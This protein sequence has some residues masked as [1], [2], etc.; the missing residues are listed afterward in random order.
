MFANDDAA[1]SILLL[2]LIGNKHNVSISQN[3]WDAWDSWIARSLIRSQTAI[4]F[5]A[6]GRIVLEIRIHVRMYIHTYTE[7]GKEGIKDRKHF[8]SCQLVMVAINRFF[9]QKTVETFRRTRERHSLALLQVLFWLFQYCLENK[10]EL[11]SSS[12]GLYLL[13]LW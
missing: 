5:R 3:S 10:T 1:E 9:S 8:V 4:S 13:F 12:P 7:E 2:G 6:G 11:I